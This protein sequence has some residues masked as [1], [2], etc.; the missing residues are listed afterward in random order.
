MPVVLGGL[1]P[2]SML[3]PHLIYRLR[4][5]LMISSS[6]FKGIGRRPLL[7]FKITLWLL[8]IALMELSWK[9]LNLT[10]R[11]DVPLLAWPLLIPGRYLARKVNPLPPFYISI[12]SLVVLVESQSLDEVSTPVQ[13]PKSPVCYALECSEDEPRLSGKS[14]APFPASSGFCA[15]R[16]LVETPISDKLSEPLLPARSHA[17][18]PVDPACDNFVNWVELSLSKAIFRG[19]HMSECFPDFPIESLRR[20]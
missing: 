12:L 9:A 4:R 3:F 8:M 20:G 10:L 15:S 5:V 19:A 14:L 1:S 16:K 6:P 2:P 13:N 7:S 17:P 18:H 11:A